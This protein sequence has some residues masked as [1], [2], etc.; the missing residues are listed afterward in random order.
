MFA[1]VAAPVGPAFVVANRGAR[2]TEIHSDELVELIYK[3]SR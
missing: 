1:S 3:H 2:E